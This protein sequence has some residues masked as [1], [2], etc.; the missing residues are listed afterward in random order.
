MFIVLAFAGAVAQGPGNTDWLGSDQQTGLRADPA[1]YLQGNFAEIGIHPSGSLGTVTGG[2]PAGYHSWYVT[3]LGFV[4]D[5][6]LDG[7]A[8]GTPPYSG[9]YFLPGA[10]FEG[11]LVEFAYDAVDYSFANAGAWGCY[12]TGCGVVPIYPEVPQTS[13]TNT[14]FGIVNSATW[15]G[16]ATGGGQSLLIEQD[17]HF[18]D[19]DA[20]FAIDVKLTNTGTQALHNVEYARVVDPDQEENYTGSYVTRNYVGHQPGGGNNLAQVVGKGTTYGIPMALQMLHPNA[21][22]HVVPINTQLY[23]SSTN[24][25]LDFTYAPTEAAPYI[26]DV[27]MAVATRIPV[28]NPGQSVMIPI[29]YVLNEDEVINPPFIPLNNWALAVLAGLIA[30]FTLIRFRKMN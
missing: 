20:K 5:F 25:P 4:A 18:T 26:A 17:F 14:S 13:L 1:I 7:W 2:I 24:E 3:G 29:A 16:T 10:P 28:L 19:N 21:R 8:N 15:T 11:W 30:I 27:G 6:N 9:D 23:I 22:A 12:Q